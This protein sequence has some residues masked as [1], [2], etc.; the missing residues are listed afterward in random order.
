MSIIPF[1]PN[2]FSNQDYK[3]I[4][5]DENR[6]L[7]PAKLGFG[8]KYHFINSGSNGISLLL[9]SFNLP[10]KA[11]VGLPPLI[12]N[13][14][15][16]A[17][18]K[19][20]FQPYFFDISKEFQLT[21]HKSLFEKSRI[22]ALVLP[23]M[24]GSANPFSEEI[25]SWCKENSV[26]LIND[27]AQ[28]FG[29]EHNGMPLIETG[30]GGI[31]SF[32]FGKSSACAGGALIYGLEKI[33]YNNNAFVKLLLQKMSEDCLK[34][35]VAGFD[36]PCNYSIGKKINYAFLRLISRGIY[37]VN[38]LQFNSIKHF[39]SIK[40]KINTKRNTNWQILN[41]E[42][43]KEIFII[44]KY[45]HN[46]QKYK[47][48]FHLEL[49]DKAIQQFIR[50]LGMTGININH[51]AQSYLTEKFRNILPN[52]FRLKNKLCEISTEAS[53]PSRNFYHAAR[54]MNNYFE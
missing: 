28:S 53:I 29:L 25:I 43:N 33:N 37:D 54:I 22:K 8:F 48:V 49:P 21:F 9:K 42:L 5:A 51:C 11:K 7:N 24:Y 13:S 10:K 30:D 4:L 41:N 2:P 12:S 46:T 50:I 18:L 34:E 44:P 3:A 20:G 31:Y 38:Y 23:H 16:L 47:Y 1:F 27:T 52:Y 6:E 39:L 19:A 17:I 32:G 15:L 40:D 35:R 45:Y 26:Y 36:I 14:V